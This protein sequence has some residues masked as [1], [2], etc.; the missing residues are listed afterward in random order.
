[1]H[2]NI[3]QQQMEDINVWQGMEHIKHNTE[4]RYEY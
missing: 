2:G 4:W 3:K 1:M